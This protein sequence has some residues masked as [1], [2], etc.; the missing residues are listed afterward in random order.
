MSDHLGPYE[1][2]TIVTGDARELAKAIPDESIDLVLT[3]PPFGIGFDYGD[4]FKDVPAMY[5]ALIE[6]LISES[7]RLIKPGGM[8][9][10]FV[11]QPQ[12]RHIWPLFPEDSRIFAACKN[13][14]Q[15]R[16]IPV[17]YSY[18]P[19]IFWK[20]AGAYGKENKGRDWHIG[21][22]AATN[23]RGLNHADH[24]C[25]RPVDTILY[26]VDNFSPYGGVVAD[27]FM[28]SGTTAIASNILGRRWWGC[29]IDPEVAERA[30]ERVRNTQPPLFVD[31][32]QQ[33]SYLETMP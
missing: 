27:F 29:E 18:D 11:P 17:Q 2:D 10:V 14:V 24:V 6:W 7:N 8:C 15:M 33:L 25:P 9:F 22:T 23:S 20:K 12:L 19:V 3:D 28:G 5:P 1:L 16:A 32:P 4:G 21:N 30:R 26:M 13:F 31:V